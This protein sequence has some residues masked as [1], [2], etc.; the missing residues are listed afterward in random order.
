MKMVI[1]YIKGLIK[2]IIGGKNYI[3]KVEV[4]FIVIYY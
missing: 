4:E 2:V 3:S 1:L